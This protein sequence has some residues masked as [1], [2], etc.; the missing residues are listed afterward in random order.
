MKS[1]KE[2]LNSL[3]EQFQNHSTT[4]GEYEDQI[5]P[6]IVKINWATEPQSYLELLRIERSRLPKGR[7]YPE[8]SNKTSI[9]LGYDNQNRLIYE[10]CTD[11]ASSGKYKKFLIYNVN[12]IWSFKYSGDKIDGIEYQ[13]L[14]DDFPIIYASFEK[15]IVN[16]VDKYEYNNDRLISIDSY[17][18]YKAFGLNP[19]QPRYEI[20]YNSLGDISEI[21]RTDEISDFFP[22]G[23][24]LVVFK[25]HDYSIKSLTEMLIEEVVILIKKRIDA[26]KFESTKCL[27]VFVSK[28]FNSDD[29]LPP[30]FS[31]VNLIENFKSDIRIDQIIDFNIVSFEHELVI[32]KRLREVSNLLMQEITIKEKYNLPYKIIKTIS[33]EIK[34]WC[35]DLSN[36]FDSSCKLII[37]PLEL[38]DDY[39]ED[40]MYVL[41]RLY[42]KN[43]IKVI[44]EHN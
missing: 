10:E 21:V 26:A 14:I 17:S 36:Q 34:L 31:F 25:R 16:T 29:W 39:S 3:Q 12:S 5:T 23:Q 44:Q 33:K 18:S 6:K 24:N 28:S 7:I 1:H 35:N 30:R 15:G 20:T 13:K 11:S 4:L 37:L 9:K 2:I 43:E 27:I 38:P 8:E 22:K 32:S 42:S 41:K 40:C 19:Q